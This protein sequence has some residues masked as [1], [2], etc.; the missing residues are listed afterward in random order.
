MLLAAYDARRPTA[1]LDALARSIAN[2]GA[3]VFSRVIEI[4]RHPPGED[5]GVEYLTSTATTRIIRHQAIC[6]GVRIAMDCAIAT[7]AVRFRL[8]VNFCDPITP[9]PNR[10]YPAA[11]SLRP[12]TRRWTHLSVRAGGH[13]GHNAGRSLRSCSQGHTG[14]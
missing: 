4:A 3:A 2:D 7:A 1:D 6:A 9:G 10:L 8:D 13:D 14:D 12:L 5:G 11:G